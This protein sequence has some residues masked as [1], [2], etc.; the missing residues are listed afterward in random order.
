MFHAVPDFRKHPLYGDG[1]T[2]DSGSATSDPDSPIG[3]VGNG[4]EVHRLLKASSES[5]FLCDVH[6]DQCVAGSIR[7]VPELFANGFHC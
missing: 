5:T 2:V 3:W 7:V 6:H 4:T 1:G